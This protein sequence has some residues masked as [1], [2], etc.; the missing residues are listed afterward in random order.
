[1]P[2]GQRRILPLTFV[3]LQIFNSPVELPDGPQPADVPA[4]AGQDGQVVRVQGEEETFRWEFGLRKQRR[5]PVCI[6]AFFMLA[7]TT[8][9]M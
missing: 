1:M 9:A 4:A 2:G 8:A 7:L 6:W 3:V 5:V